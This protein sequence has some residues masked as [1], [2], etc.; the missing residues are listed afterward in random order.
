MN[1]DARRKAAA[2]FQA[3]RAAEGWR[4]VTIAMHP[5]TLAELDVLAKIYGSKAEAVAKAINHHRSA[6]VIARAEAAAAP[7]M[8]APKAPYGSRLKKR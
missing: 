5:D 3:K 4:K 8:S 2:A 6:K 1:T 7:K